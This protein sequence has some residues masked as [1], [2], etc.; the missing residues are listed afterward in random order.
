M[1]I[2]KKMAII[3][4]NSTIDG[5]QKLIPKDRELLHSGIDALQVIIAKAI[6]DTDNGPQFK[7]LMVHINESITEWQESDEE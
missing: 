4:A 6:D 7:A 5:I 1:G 2:D 3:I